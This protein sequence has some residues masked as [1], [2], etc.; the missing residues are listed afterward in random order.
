MRVLILKIT[1]SF[2]FIFLIQNHALI[3]LEV[4]NCYIK[5]TAKH[6]YN[7]KL[8]KTILDKEL[9]ALDSNMTFFD[10]AS[11]LSGKITKIADIYLK[12]GFLADAYAVPNSDPSTIISFYCFPLWEGE[13]S[14][15]ESIPLTF[16]I[17]IWPSEDVALKYNSSHPLNSRYGSIIHSHPIPCAFAV[18]QG[19]LVQ[20]NYERIG[21]DPSMKFVR[22]IN[23]DIFKKGEGDVDNLTIPFIHQLYGRN[24]DSNMCLSLHA[25][26]LPSAQKVMKCFKET[27]SDCAYNISH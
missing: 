13:E 24:S 9:D 26:G 18:L 2:L 14:N 3:G 16:F 19:M 5:D 25:Y 8:L 22:L 1:A 4:K 20:K 11:Y 23:E 12:Q 7:Q 10:Q 15:K 27:F 17:Y 21:S 6:E